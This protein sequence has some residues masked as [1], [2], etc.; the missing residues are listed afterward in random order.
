MRKFRLSEKAIY[1]LVKHNAKKD[2]RSGVYVGHQI[3]G[4]ARWFG[5]CLLVES[6]CNYVRTSPIVAARKTK[7][8]YTLKT[9][10]GSTY[11]LSKVKINKNVDIDGILVTE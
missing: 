9:Q 7:A 1:S 6:N 11:K 2:Q 4:L 3:T 8:G 10:N 5:K